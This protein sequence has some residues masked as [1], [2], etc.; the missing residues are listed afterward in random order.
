MKPREG[1]T[2]N[3][4]VSSSILTLRMTGCLYSIISRNNAGMTWI[5]FKMLSTLFS[6]IRFLTSFFLILLLRIFKILI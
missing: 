1:T 2:L 6:T 4:S 5:S 3:R